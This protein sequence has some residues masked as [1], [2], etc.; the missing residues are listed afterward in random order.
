MKYKHVY[1]VNDIAT[2]MKRCSKN[3]FQSGSCNTSLEDDFIEFSYISIFYHYLRKTSENKVNKVQLSSLFIDWIKA[4]KIND[5][6]KKVNHKMI[7]T[8]LR[9]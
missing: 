7:S 4:L 8:T 3:N 6:N 5:L 2:K 9:N 1:I